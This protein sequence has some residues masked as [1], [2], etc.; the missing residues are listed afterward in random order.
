MISLTKLTPRYRITLEESWYHEKPEV[1]KIDRRWY[2]QI[3]CRGGGFIQLHSEDP[4]LLKLWTPQ[5]KSARAISREFPALKAEF[6]DGEAVI[7]FPPELLEQIAR[8]AGAKR[9]RKMGAVHKERFLAAGHRAL[10][11]R[12][13]GQNSLSMSEKMPPDGPENSQGMVNPRVSSER[14]K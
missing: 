9:R 4:P 3:P 13:Q 7:Y 5:I 8:M 12:R 14:A 2:E 10:E 6:L 1:R 11:V